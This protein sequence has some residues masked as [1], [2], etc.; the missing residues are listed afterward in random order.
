MKDLAAQNQDITDE[1]EAVRARREFIKKC[2]KYAV[3]IPP[4]M[5]L[6]LTRDASATGLYLTGFT[7]SP[8]FDN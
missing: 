3:V 2:G 6:I 1:D 4:A 7:G 8:T 5:A